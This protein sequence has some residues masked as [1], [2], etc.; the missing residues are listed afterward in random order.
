MKWVLQENE[1]TAETNF[2]FS[3]IHINTIMNLIISPSKPK[4]ANGTQH[5]KIHNFLNFGI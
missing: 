5:E 4:L 2:P 3:S 1:T